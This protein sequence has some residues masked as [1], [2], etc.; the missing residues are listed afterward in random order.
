[1]NNFAASIGQKL[2]AGCG[3]FRQ[4][5][6][7]RRLTSFGLPPFFPFSL[8]AFAFFLVLIEPS[9]TAAEF[10]GMAISFKP[11]SPSALMVYPNTVTYAA[12][13]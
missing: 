1:M 10:L 4:P 9:A 7:V 5:V 3:I 6:W 13:H 11:V 8:A 12:R 2:S